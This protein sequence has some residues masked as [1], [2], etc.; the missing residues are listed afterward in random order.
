L[1]DGAG[2]VVDAG[3][4]L[5]H[6]LREGSRVTLATAVQKLVQVQVNPYGVGSIR[7]HRRPP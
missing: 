4:V 2:R 3:L 6:Q 7:R 1:Q 5:V